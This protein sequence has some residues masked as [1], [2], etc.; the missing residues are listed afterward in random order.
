MFTGDW[1][2]QEFDLTVASLDVK[3][4]GTLIRLRILSGL[5]N[6]LQNLQTYAFLFSLDILAHSSRMIGVKLSC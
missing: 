5:K 4:N 2:Q 1:F 6:F 3:R